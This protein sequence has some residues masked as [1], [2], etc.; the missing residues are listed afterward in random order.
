MS[1]LQLYPVRNPTPDAYGCQA[2][3]A[4]A[5]APNFL[6]DLLS[7]SSTLIGSDHRWKVAALL[8]EFADAFSASDDDLDKTGI[9]RH[10]MDPPLMMT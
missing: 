6:K 5:K 4:S 1:C 2:R 9:L 3:N 10:R 7:R 8:T